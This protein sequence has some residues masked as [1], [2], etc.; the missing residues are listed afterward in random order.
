MT[1]P[2]T[3]YTNTAIELNPNFAE[4]YNN[5]GVRLRTTKAIMTMLLKTLTKAIE[6]NPEW[7]RVLITIVESDLR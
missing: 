7:C 4:T 2:L 3:D 1:V 6:L 5:R